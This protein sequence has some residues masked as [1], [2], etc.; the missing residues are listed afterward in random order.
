MKNFPENLQP[1][2]RTLFTELRFN[3]LLE[4]WRKKIYL[5]ILS[6]DRSGLDIHIDNTQ[7]DKKIIDC[8]RLELSSLGWK[9]Q[10]AYNGTVLF[11]Y[12]NENEIE[13]YKHGL[14]EDIFE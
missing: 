7:I 13:K 10:L 11:I 3:E 14:C 4:N 6:N 1:K 9:T 12:E 5:Y 8:L 2:Y